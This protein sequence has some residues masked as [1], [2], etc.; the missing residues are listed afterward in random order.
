MNETNQDRTWELS[1]SKLHGEAS[2]SEANELNELTSQTGNKKIADTV[3][4]LHSQLKHT[5][6]LHQGSLIS[7]WD[8]VA[9][10]IHRKKLRFYFSFSKYAAIAVLAFGAGTV[11][12]YSWKANNTP[13]PVFAEI[14]VP[15]GQ[16]TEMTLF[17]GTH[18]W[19]NSGTT[20]RY[21]NNFG[22]KN[23]QVELEGEAF[24]KVETSDIPFRVKIKNNEVE[25]LGTSFAAVAYPD[26]EFSQV[27]LVEGSVQINDRNGYAIT[28]LKPNQQLH[29]PDNQNEKI[30]IREVNTLFY[31][32]WI[33]GQIKFD[34]ERLAD[35]ARRMERWYNVEIRFACKEASEMR[36]TGTVLKNKPVDQSMQAISMLLPI[37]VKHERNLHIKDVITIKKKSAYD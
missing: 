33:N 6:P 28:N 35:V 8:K 17:D 23:R 3:Y 11:I 7:S 27:T 5:T 37:K 32:S 18:V 36:F 9:Q 25:V 21:A 14:Q 22:N 20:L 30:I 19:L 1:A 15:L 2:E 26:E 34:E 29:L 4:D 24:F 31:E 16:M 10:Y 12:N 13:P